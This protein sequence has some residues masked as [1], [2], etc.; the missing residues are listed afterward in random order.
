MFVADDRS[1][2][3]WFILRY[4]LSGDDMARQ[5]PRRTRSERQSVLSPSLLQE[6]HPRST[7]SLAIMSAINFETYCCS[8]LVGR[9][10]E[11]R[12]KLS[13]RCITEGRRQSLS[14]SP[15]TLALR[16]K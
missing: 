13:D 3:M 10:V 2:E 14:L 5:T 6:S 16:P 4:E 7:T 12:G 11:N 9:I 15:M 1:Y 8:H